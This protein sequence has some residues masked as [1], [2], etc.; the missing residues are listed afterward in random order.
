MTPPLAISASPTSPTTGTASTAFTASATPA[1]VLGYW[2]IRGLAEP[3]RLLCALLALP[4]QEKVYNDPRAWAHDRAL[5]ETPFANLPYY[6]DASGT[7][8]ETACILEHLA[9]DQLRDD[10]V[11]HQAFHFLLSCHHVLRTF[12]YGYVPQSATRAAKWSTGKTGSLALAS[13]D[14]AAY[15]HVLGDQIAQCVALCEPGRP[16]LH[17]AAPGVCDVLLYC[18]LEMGR[19]VELDAER[20]YNACIDAILQA[21]IKERSSLS[22]TYGLKTLKSSKI[23]RSSSKRSSRKR[24]RR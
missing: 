20:L 1:P 24:S 23:S 7:R 18:L 5:L 10:R 17:G 15:R 3:I 12:C 21:L 13:R 11:C 9:G 14:P 2:G 6:T 22:D 19:S 8:C 16:F 4:L